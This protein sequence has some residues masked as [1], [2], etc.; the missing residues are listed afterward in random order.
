MKVGD[1]A[2]H[3]Y[4]SVSDALK[5]GTEIRTYAPAHIQDSVERKTERGVRQPHTSIHHV[6]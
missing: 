4:E 2:M 3:G 5:Q 1:K 6:H